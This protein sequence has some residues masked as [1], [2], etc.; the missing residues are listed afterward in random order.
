MMH[1]SEFD[2]EAQIFACA[3]GEKAALHRLYDQEARWLMGV[4]QRIVRRREL[5][6]EILHDAFLQIWQKSITY[7]P[8]LGSARGWIYTVV[9]N[10][11]INSVRR[12]QGENSASDVEIENLQDNQ[13]G[14][15]DTLSN[16]QEISALHHC[17]EHLDEQ[18]RA[19]ILLAYVDG[20]SQSQIANHL[21][22]P[23][24]TI[25]AWTRRGLM[26]LKECLS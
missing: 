12:H 11:A 2:Y 21:A 1:K 22:C 14:P 8:V 23:L 17:L 7:N 13:P 16:K 4:I 19:C 18:K 9:R 10:Q 24:G 26:A 6:D 25:K 15:L 20:Y 5:A 3:R